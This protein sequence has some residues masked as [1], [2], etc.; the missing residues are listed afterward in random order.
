[1][2]IYTQKNKNCKSES[3]LYPDFN[4]GYYSWPLTGSSIILG[5][6]IMVQSA[7]VLDEYSPEVVSYLLITTNQTNLTAELMLMIF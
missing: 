4:M 3:A 6:L 5:V 1:M 7:V 2:S